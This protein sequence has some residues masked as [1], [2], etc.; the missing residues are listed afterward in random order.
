MPAASSPLR[1]GWHVPGHWLLILAKGNEVAAPELNEK[2]GWAGWWEL[3]SGVAAVAKCPA[4]PRA[5]SWVGGREL[6]E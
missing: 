5:R 6:G 1:Q 2:G 3:A 4:H